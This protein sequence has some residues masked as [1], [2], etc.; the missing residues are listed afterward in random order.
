MIII[1]GAMLAVLCLG[2]ALEVV[3]PD[4]LTGLFP[5]GKEQ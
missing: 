1:I 2:C 4:A 3:C 5:G